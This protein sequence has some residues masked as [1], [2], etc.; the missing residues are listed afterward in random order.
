LTTQKD[1]Q[2]ALTGEQ[3]S[4][5]QGDR[6]DVGRI[7]HSGVVAIG[8][9]ARA[10]INNYTEI[11]V[12]SD[13]IEDLP[14]VPGEPPFKGLAYF[15][16]QDA[17]IFFGREELSDQIAARLLKTRFLAVIGASGSGKSSLLRAGVIPRMRRKN[18]S[19]KVMT[20]TSRPLERLATILT[21]DDP[22]LT[23]ADEM[24]E[25]LVQNPRA[26]LLAANKLAARQDKGYLL[27]VVDQFEEL[28]TLCHDEH[29]RQ[30]FIDNLLTAV[31]GEGAVTILIGLRADFYDRCA[32]YE[33]LRDLV[34]RQQEFI[35]PMR[36]EDL[37][38]VIA[39]PAKRGGWQFVDGLVEQI[40][41]DVG[42][43]PGRLPLLSHA[44]L[45]T[46]RLRRGTVMTLGGY[47]AAGGVEGAIAKTAEN[48]LKNFD[49]EQMTIVEHIFLSLTELGQ[50]AEDTRRIA[51]KDELV[52][53]E[54]A[55]NVDVVL[56]DLVRARLVTIDGEQVEVAHEALIRR[57]PRLE[58][59]LDENRER[60]QFE[61]QLSQ[62][63]QKWEASQRDPGYL[64]RGSR[65]QQ[66]L[67]WLD[68]LDEPLSGSEQEFIDASRAVEAEEERRAEQLRS[69]QKRQR[70]LIG[71]AVVLLIAVVAAGFFGQ[72]LTALFR[73]PGQM[74]GGFNIAV[75]VM[76]EGEGVPEGS[77]SAVSTRIGVSLEEALAN[78]SDV[79]VWYDS[80]ELRRSQNVVIGE[81]NP[82]NDPQQTP[83]AK[84]ESLQAD[85]LIYGSIVQD[86]SSNV[87]QLQM[88][89][90][91]QFG[92]DVGNMGGLYQ[93]TEPIPLF[94]PLDPGL[95]IQKPVQALA[96]MALG[97]S[98]S[99]L[100]Q[101]D[102]ALDHFQQAADLMPHSDMVHYFV[103][104]EL[105]HLANQDGDTAA[106]H[107]D[108]AEAAFLR[109]LDEN[110][111]ARA[112]IGLGSVHLER[113]Q[114]L[115]D[116]AQTEDCTSADAAGVLQEV[117]AETDAA[118]AEFL[119]VPQRP[120][121]IDL[122]EY[123]G[124]VN[125][126]V[127]LDQGILQRIRANSHFCLG[128]SQ[129]AISDLN[130]GLA[131]LDVA[132]PDF[133][134]V[135]YHR[136]L[137]RLYQARGTLYHWLTFLLVQEQDDGSR[138]ALQKG[139]QAL[140]Q[141]LQ[142]G[143]LAPVDEFL[144]TVIIPLCEDGLAELQAAGGVQ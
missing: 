44:L 25:A 78:F 110:E 103:G 88:Y 47:R 29:E 107:L 24:R 108:Q 18:W 84:A 58:D 39:E 117:L 8:R 80:P 30:L 109:A 122:A 45:E 37:V 40:L 50:Q 83:Q 70:I 130:S 9:G 129:T 10:T 131:D 11:I 36:Q 13:S 55:E 106:D 90:K 17:D 143:E 111:N 20:P 16:E 94:D 113:A 48:L 127:H 125:G 98:F 34:S 81:V 19:I 77:G 142:Q 57:W 140:G 49:T 66:T 102:E 116:E 43:E 35:G 15:T 120:L 1:K 14:P 114:A 95:E 61:R 33:G 138:E 91:P 38:R 119:E 46:W 22:S 136:S 32:D 82:D 12:Q 76:E 23:A 27:L 141:C 73:E 2:E 75:A 115:L 133:Q 4:E 59:W 92:A 93:F 144:Q 3:P 97:L 63:V 99:Q 53:G 67:G 68:Q 54:R 101:A 89:L 105:F 26:L 132:E 126:I 42:R 65:L 134:Q 51:S 87:L 7:E 64:Y 128:D 74:E 118:Q 62:D 124:P 52:R 21:G 139:I 100:G 69:A 104:Q 56:E 31:A 96:Q 71:V 86:G 79:E 41:E 28:F 6:I 121:A 135:S 60:L 85:A 5:S 137:A 123:G 72:N 112:R